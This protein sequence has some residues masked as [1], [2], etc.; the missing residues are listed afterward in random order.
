MIQ[1]ISGSA[2]LIPSPGQWVKDPALLQPW[3]RSQLQFNFDPSVA[4]EFPYAKGAGVVEGRGR[5][6]TQYGTDTKS[7]T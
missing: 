2:C 5:G 3:Y 6:D 1:L 4:W 7:N